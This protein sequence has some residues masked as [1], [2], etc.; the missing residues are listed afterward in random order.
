MEVKVCG[1][2]RPEDA[3]AAAAA[4]ADLL[5]VILDAASARR[6]GAGEA[7]AIYQ[8]AGGVQR[9]GVFAD[10]P[11]EAVIA[12]AA[13]L[14]LDVVQLHGDELA[15]DVERIRAGGPW[16]VWKALRP[17]AADELLRGIDAYAGLVDGLLVDGWS[18]TAAGGSGVR[19]PW[20]ELRAAR[21]QV[22]AHVRFILAGGLTAANVGAAIAALKPDV[23]DVSSGVEH[24]L[25]EKSA[26]AMRAF[27]AA[28]RGARAPGV[29]V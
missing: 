4:G 16:S 15:D 5:G 13:S 18:A 25:G 6:R 8:A 2:C 12:A 27:V 29:E 22:P 23:V 11:V 19:A 10:A 1:V 24:A 7:A 21:D 28:A 26:E 20:T 9:A 17:R 14:G 3:A